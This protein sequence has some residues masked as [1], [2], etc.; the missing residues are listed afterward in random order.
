MFDKF[1]HRFCRDRKGGY[2]WYDYHQANHARRFHRYVEAHGLM[3]QECGGMG[4]LYE[5]TIAEHAIYIECGWCLGSGRVPRH[6]RGTW[7]RW[8]REEKREAHARP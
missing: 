1:T 4:Q 3:C 7:L 8:K 2:A 6:L 5:E